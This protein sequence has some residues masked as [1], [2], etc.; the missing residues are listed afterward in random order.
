MFE[1]EERQW[2]YAGQRAIADALLEPPWAAAGRMRPRLLDA[3]CGTGFNLRGASP[4]SARA[5]GIDLSPEAIAF[6]RERGVRAVAARACS[7]CPSRR[8]PS[9]P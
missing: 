4:A 1:A 2:W 5:V 9:T 7:R 3:G 6:C 8:Q